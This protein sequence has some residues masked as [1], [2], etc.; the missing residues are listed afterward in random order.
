MTRFARHVAAARFA[1]LGSC[2][3]QC[4][5][6]VAP[7]RRH[8]AGYR[9]YRAPTLARRAMSVHLAISAATDLDDDLLTRC[10]GEFVGEA[11]EATRPRVYATSGRTWL[12]P[13]VMGVRCAPS[14]GHPSRARRAT[15]QSTVAANRVG[16]S[17]PCR[18]NRGAWR[19]AM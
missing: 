4:R 18:R 7:H 16:T 5:K 14:T 12:T 8:F 13:A 19:F 1:G 11:G 2:Y 9:R 6:D 15:S 17:A 10:L 3:V